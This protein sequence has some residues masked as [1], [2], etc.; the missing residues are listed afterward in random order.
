MF[1]SETHP[2]VVAVA[3]LTD[4]PHAISTVVLV[5]V[6]HVDGPTFT[7]EVDG[8]IFHTGCLGCLCACANHA[9]NKLYILQSYFRIFHISS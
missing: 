9:V 1:V 7:P 8:V 5:E 2:L 6:V 3:L 4:I